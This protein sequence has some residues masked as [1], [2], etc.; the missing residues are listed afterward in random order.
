MRLTSQNPQAK[1]SLVLSISLLFLAVGLGAF[2]S[3]GL[4]KIAT[5]KAIKTF[6]T[7]VTYQYYHAFAIFALGLLQRTMERPQIFASC[8]WLFLIGI[9]LFSFNCYIYALSGVKVFALIVPLGGLTFLY[10]WGLSLF[11]AWKYL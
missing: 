11:K 2:G 7:G 3:H 10:A 9:I 4:E 1:T 6:K 8:R 5:E